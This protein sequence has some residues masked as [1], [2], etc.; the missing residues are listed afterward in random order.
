MKRSFREPKNLFKN[1]AKSDHRKM[2]TLK[3]A[4]SFRNKGLYREGKTKK[5]PKLTQDMAKIRTSGDSKNA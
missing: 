1:K 3:S 5:T 4:Q 2:N